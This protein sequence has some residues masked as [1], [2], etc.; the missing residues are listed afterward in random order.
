MVKHNL[1]TAIERAEPPAGTAVA[2]TP[3]EVSTRLA[4]NN[5]ENGCIDGRYWVGDAESARIFATLCLEFTRA[6]AEKRLA[7]V[8]KLPAGRPD[9]DAGPG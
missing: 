8:E 4:S 7:A 3:L 9:Y 5:R 2:A 6:T 1:V